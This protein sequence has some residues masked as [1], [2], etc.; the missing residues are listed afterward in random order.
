MLLAACAEAEKQGTERLCVGP[1]VHLWPD[2]WVRLLAEQPCS[3][4]CICLT[5][6][7]AHVPDA[8]QVLQERTDLDFG[9]FWVLNHTKN[10]VTLRACTACVLPAAQQASK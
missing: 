6:C 8:A 2:N 4:L 10:A 3:L 5:G 9:R 7:C 1:A